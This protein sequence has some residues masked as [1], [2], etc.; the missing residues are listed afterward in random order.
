MNVFYNIIIYTFAVILLTLP[1]FSSAELPRT[2]Q[3]TCYDQEGNIISHEGTGQDGDLQAGRIWPEPRF[4]DNGDGTITDLLTDLMWLK[5][6]SCLGW[7]SWQAAMNAAR[8]LN[9]MG[10]VEKHCAGLTVSYRDWSLPSI[11]ELETLLNAEEKDPY[12]FLNFYGFQGVQ[13]DSYWSSTAGPNPYSAWLLHFDSAEVLAGGKVESHHVLLVRK[14]RKVRSE[15]P[16]EI[17]PDTP[18]ATPEKIER[19]IDNG[20]GTVTDTRTGLMWLKDVSCIDSLDWQSGLEAINKFNHDPVS[21]NCQD[22]TAAHYDDWA[23]PNRNELRSLISYTADLPA[24]ATD[25]PTDSIQP[26]YWT[27]TIV[28]GHP[29]MAYDLYMGTGELTVRPKDDKRYIWPVRPSQGRI[30]RQRV[31]D[32]TETI[33]LKAEHYLLRPI[34]NR[35][36]IEWPARRFTDH[37]DGTVIDNLTGLMWLKDGS[38]LGKHNWSDAVLM[39]GLL[40]NKFEKIDCEEYSAD[41]NNW[42]LP[43]VNIFKSLVKGLKKTPAQW[44]NSQGV[45][46]V[47]PLDYWSVTQN[48]L[49]LY[50]A[51]AMNFGKGEERNYPKTFEFFVWP[52]RRQLVIGPV[53]PKV[54]LK[55]NGFSGQFR[56]SQSQEL[57]LSASVDYNKGVIGADYKIWYDAPDG[58][59]WW[60]TGIGEWSLQERTLFRGNMFL[61][62]EYTVFHAGTSNLV[63]GEYV[64]H[65]SVTPLLGKDPPL[66]F[67]S[68]LVLTLEEA[69]DTDDEFDEEVTVLVE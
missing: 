61:L 5:N 66:V 24:L 58:E 3:R 37:G 50:H 41:Y 33:E 63:P 44:L 42:Q 25:F 26:Y 55:G 22:L 43:G 27:S 40:N 7:L 47:A 48:P 32:K 39:V 6:G 28:A 67:S 65:F 30:L 68:D 2:G 54:S 59:T 15:V 45:I 4:Q 36:R 62:D 18:V 29:D 49:N 31:P 21:F 69:S 53:N 46:K 52:V 35:I 19:F 57:I 56:L 10:R 17:A 60:L 1:S 12:S 9:S 38:C 8:E 20:D 34:G 14:V 13:P 51:W 64:F 11:Q 23:L 16:K